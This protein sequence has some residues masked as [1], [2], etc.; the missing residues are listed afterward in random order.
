MFDQVVPDA[1]WVLTEPS[2]YVVVVV[3]PVSSELPQK[4]VHDDTSLLTPEVE[5]LVMR[6]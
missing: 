3:I 1:F 5:V 4:A 6:G 2:E